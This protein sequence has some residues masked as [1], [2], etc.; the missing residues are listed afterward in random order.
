M[1][2]DNLQLIC[3]F[4]ELSSIRKFKK[5][6]LLRRIFKKKPTTL[7]ITNNESN[8]NNECKISEDCDDYLNDYNINLKVNLPHGLFLPI[9]SITPSYKDP[10][11][12]LEYTENINRQFYTNYNEIGYINNSSSSMCINLFGKRPL[13]AP[14]PLRPRKTRRLVININSKNIDNIIDMANHICNNGKPTNV[15]FKRRKKLKFLKKNMNKQNQSK[16]LDCE[17]NEKQFQ[18]A[19]KPP[20]L[21]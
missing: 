3:K 12:I 4:Q 19:I 8:N 16:N 2:P 5:L 1:E 11:Y 17:T 18:L 7:A 21:G 14:S 20:T 6:K 9:P 15:S 13:T 10:S